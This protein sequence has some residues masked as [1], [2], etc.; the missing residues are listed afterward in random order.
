LHK[1]RN[2][3]RIRIVIH[4]CSGNTNSLHWV[5]IRTLN[6]P[7]LVMTMTI[8]MVV[9][10]NVT[11][12]KMDVGLKAAAVISGLA[13]MRMRNQYQ[14]PRQVSQ[15]HEDGN[16]APDHNEVYFPALV[17]ACTR[18]ATI[19]AEGAFHGV[20]VGIIVITRSSTHSNATS[21]SSGFAAHIN[22]FGYPTAKATTSAPNTARPSS[23]TTTPSAAPPKP[24]K[25]SSTPPARSPPRS[26][27]NHT[28]QKLLPGRKV[29]SRLLPLQPGPKLLRGGDPAEG[30]EV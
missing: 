14:L 18:R 7:L 12:R 11:Y 28:L 5:N 16:G 20:L 1:G 10:A 2:V 19:V 30:G 29:P 27:P 24:T 8:F 15:E 25:I 9:V 22:P 6:E 13:S 26:S 3:D 4:A 23:T 21:A 17:Y